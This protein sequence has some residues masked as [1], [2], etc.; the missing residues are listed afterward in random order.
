MMQDRLYMKY[1]IDQDLYNSALSYHK[2][3]QD[4]EVISIMREVDNHMTPE[5]KARVAESLIRYQN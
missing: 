1:N 3:V 2:M 5:E 4:P